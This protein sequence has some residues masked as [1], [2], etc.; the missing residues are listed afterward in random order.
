MI[1]VCMK[2]KMLRFIKI[3]Y[4]DVKKSLHLSEIAET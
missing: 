1:N 4:Y 3:K 2:L